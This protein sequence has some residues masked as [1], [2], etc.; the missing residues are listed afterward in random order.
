VLDELIGHPTDKNGD[1]KMHRNTY[2]R[3]VTGISECCLEV[4]KDNVDEKPV[5]D[6]K[7]IRGPQHTV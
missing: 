4:V 5:T 6:N 7:V 3:H 1:M 2:F